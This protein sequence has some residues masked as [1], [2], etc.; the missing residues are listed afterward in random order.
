MKQNNVLILGAAGRDFHDFNTYFRNNKEYK[1]VGFTAAQ[2]PDIAGR[3][4]PK[5]LAGRL[6]PKGI[7]I[8]DEKNLEKLIH[9]LKVDIVTMSY[10]DIPHQ[11][12]MELGSRVMASDAHFMMLGPH[13]TMIKSKKP[14]VAVCAVRTGCGKSP[15]SRAVA[16]H[17]LKRN[18]RV[19]AIRHPMPYGDLRKQ[20]CQRFASY[21]DFD[22]YKCTIEEREE[23]E[24]WI[25]QGMIIYAGVD[26][27]KILRQAEK[28][29]DVIIWDGGNN[30]VP[31][32][33]PDLHIVLADPHR[34][35]DELTYYP[36][37]VNIRMADTVI[38]SKSNTASKD[39]IATV[40]KNVTQVNPKAKQILGSLSL[41][42]DQ[43]NLVKG[44]RVLAVE[45]GPTLTHG[46]MKY[47]A[48]TLAAK[49][50][51]AKKLVDPR[52]F[53]VGKLKDTF[54]TYPHIGILLPAM[55]YGKQQVEDLQSTINRTKCD[56]VIDGSPVDLQKL[57][58][59]NKPWAIVNYF[60]EDR[61]EL[62]SVL[63]K[64][65]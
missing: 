21:S 3:K 51:K 34:P 32:Y 45:D 25:E 11:H 24:P 49:K 42:I 22:K 62:D 10:S 65:K 8:Y 2:I 48:A 35:G 58:S 26:Y 20:I 18:K 9:K 63:K 28:E 27:E 43:P 52:P 5:E 6:Y 17:F 19:V 46:G 53:T 14:V 29:A 40:R 13:E 38:I 16:H 55:G 36:G 30:D 12:V 41:S 31:F 39:Q 61:G 15:V 54:K 56:V 7:P 60:Y 57:I 1:V 4:Y 33:K 50:F 59:I 37:A 44:K 23:Y 47:G 64:I